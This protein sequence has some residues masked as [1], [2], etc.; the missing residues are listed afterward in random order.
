MG[1]LNATLSSLSIFYRLDPQLIKIRKALEST[2]IRLKIT[3]EASQQIS[4]GIT[5]GPP[6]I[7]IGEYKET[8]ISYIKDRYQLHANGHFDNMLEVLNCIYDGFQSI[9]YNL[10][11]IT[12]FYELN[13][14]SIEITGDSFS[15]NL[16]N[17][18]SIKNLETLQ[19]K[20]GLELKPWGF[21]VAYPDSPM[22]D[23]WFHFSINS[24]YFN[25]E[26]IGY[27]NIVR[28][29]EKKAEMVDF[30]GRIPDFIN[31]IVLHYFNGK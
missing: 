26:N 18:V 24:D 12:R 6:R 4:P 5:L 17:N 30:L 28:R 11:E 21:S 8:N 3:P 1:N 27:A 10:D 15:Q 19:R 31:E 16:V 23:Q 9:N 29:T 2:E 20:L 25:P 14:H 7:L 22:S 13:I